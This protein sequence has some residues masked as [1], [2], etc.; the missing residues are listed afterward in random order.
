MKYHAIVDTVSEPLLV[1]NSEGKI[2]YSNEA[3]KNF[4]GDQSLWVSYE[5]SRQASLDDAGT[6]GSA[7]EMARKSGNSAS[8][9]IRDVRPTG[10]DNSYSVN[11]RYDKLENLYLLQFDEMKPSDEH[12]SESM[13]SREEELLL[14]IESLKHEIKNLSFHIAHDLKA[15]LRAINGFGDFLKKELK[16]ASPQVKN[17][18][19][20]ILNNSGRMGR[21]VD[22]LKVYSDI[23]AMK[24]ELVDMDMR[25]AC[26]ESFEKLK[27]TFKDDLDRINLNIKKMPQVKADVNLTRKVLENL[28]SNAIKFA[29]PEKEILLEIGGEKK[30]GSYVYYVKDN[31]IGFDKKDLNRAFKEFQKIHKLSTND[32]PGMGLPIAKRCMEQQG[33]KIWAEGEAGKGATFYFAFKER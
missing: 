4:F 21:M 19:D 7:M 15:P 6:V 28:I 17:G 30:D 20:I 11:I 16:D 13:A 9:S 18:L 25:I 14:Q 29:Q 8:V 10:G 23:M 31:G 26:R 2:I 27:F 3:Y 22:S 33:G 5:L 12:E 24:V 32:G 1:I